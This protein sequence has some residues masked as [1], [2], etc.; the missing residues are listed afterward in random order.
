MTNK[1]LEGASTSTVTVQTEPLNLEK[2]VEIIDKFFINELHKE[3]RTS[4]QVKQSYF[5]T[6]FTRFNG[7]MDFKLPIIT[8]AQ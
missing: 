7:T 3:I 6:N 5:F 1:L 4:L 8:I 2:L